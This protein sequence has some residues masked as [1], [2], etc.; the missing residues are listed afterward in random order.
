MAKKIDILLTTTDQRQISQDYYKTTVQKYPW[1]LTSWIARAAQRKMWKRLI[2]LDLLKE[3]HDCT[4]LG[5]QHSPF[6][7][8]CRITKELGLDA[9][10]NNSR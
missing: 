1:C 10:D 7:R 9:K 3:H 6:C 5:T 8:W 2:E 4:K